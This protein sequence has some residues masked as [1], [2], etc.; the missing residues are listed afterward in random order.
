VKI[1]ENEYCLEECE[2]F[3]PMFKENQDFY[4]NGQRIGRFYLT[5]ESSVIV[6]RSENNQEALYKTINEIKS[7]AILCAH[8]M[9]LSQQSGNK[10]GKGQSET[11]LKIEQQIHDNILALKTATDQSLNVI[12]EIRKEDRFKNPN[13]GN[14]EIIKYP[15]EFNENQMKLSHTQSADWADHVFTIENTTTYVWKNLSIIFVQNNSFNTNFDDKNYG[16][17]LTEII[18]ILPKQTITV[19][20]G[21][22]DRLIEELGFYKVQLF[23]HSQP[24]SNKI[25]LASVSVVGYNIKGAHASLDVLNSIRAIPSFRITFTNTHSNLC[26]TINQKLNARKLEKVNIP[27]AKGETYELHFYKDKESILDLCE[28]YVLKVD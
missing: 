23:Y 17:R 21:Y 26:K 1:Q 28:P 3:N 9:D 4:E 22:T 11:I 12:K 24:I 20:V 27:V 6:T 15:T 19:Q 14:R 8:V 2:V 13:I 18:E 10:I 16:K 7:N 25:D 5:S